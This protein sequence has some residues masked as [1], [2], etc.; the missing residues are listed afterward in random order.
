MVCSASLRLSI[1]DSISSSTILMIRS[2]GASLIKLRARTYS[3][4]EGEII[5]HVKVRKPR[6]G[7]EV[8]KIQHPNYCSDWWWVW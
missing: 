2:S 3:G 5:A 8:F 6:L 1:A 7:S 4:A